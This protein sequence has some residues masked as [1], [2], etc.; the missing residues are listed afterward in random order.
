[1]KLDQSAE[2]I[3]IHRFEQSTKRSQKG[4]AFP[5]VLTFID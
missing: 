5:N 1:M 2:E 4:N 3:G